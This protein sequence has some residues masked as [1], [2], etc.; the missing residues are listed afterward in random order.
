LSNKDSVFNAYKIAEGKY[1]NKT[2]FVVQKGEIFSHGE[3][4]KQAVHDLRYKL[5]DRDTTKYKDWTIDTI[6]PLEQVIASYMCITGACSTGT[7]MFCEGKTLPEKL[8]I[9]KAIELTKGAY[10]SEQFANFFKG[11]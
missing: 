3:T 1:R 2:I 4:V 11:K 5:S 6:K 7:K 10:R 9:K 8:S